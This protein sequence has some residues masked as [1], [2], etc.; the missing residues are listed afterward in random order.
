[1]TWAECLRPAWAFDEAAA[2]LGG[3]IL[4]SAAWGR[5]KEQF[6]WQPWRFWHTARGGVDQTALLLVRE[7]WPGFK[8]GYLP[9]G[10]VGA[11][12]GAL[13]EFAAFA[14]EAGRKLGCL[15][16]RIDPDLPAH[17]LPHAALQA[18]GFRLRRARGEFGGIQP[19]L[20]FRRALGDRAP[21]PSPQLRRKLHRAAAAGDW[22]IEGLEGLQDFWGLLR[23]TSRRQG[24]ATRAEGY[25]RAAWR[26]LK[27][28]GL[29]ELVV[30]RRLG[31]ATAAGIVARF[32]SRA[33]YLF[34][35]SASGA[36]AHL[37]G[38]R[39]QQGMIDWATGQGCSVYDLRGGSLRQ[40][41][42]GLNRFKRQFGE[43]TLLA[44]ESDLPLH[45]RYLAFRLAEE[46]RPRLAPWL[47]AAGG[48]GARGLQPE[49]GGASAP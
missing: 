25:Y 20:V 49:P 1:M 24:I 10:P 22:R 38:Y 16:W 42:H 8:I 34:G 37:P 19:H 14:R 4:Q 29:G 11:V 27:A 36:R 32:G 21:A 35:A 31:E 33:T 9:R 43:E 7:P 15:C 39:L 48:S 2:A 6:G 18:A 23:D 46:L 3:D 44:G 12:P 13:F 41:D 45:L 28:S 26:V 17:E 5:L 30:V 40:G 47:S